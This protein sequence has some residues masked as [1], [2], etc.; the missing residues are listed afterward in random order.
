MC[1]TT[2]YGRASGLVKE[3]KQVAEKHGQAVLS[4]ESMS[5]VDDGTLFKSLRCF[6]DTLTSV[7]SISLRP[8]PDDQRISPI[9]IIINLA[10]KL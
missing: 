4:E 3:R 5:F 9:V 7:S 2:Y 6:D 1:T 8:I 10:Q